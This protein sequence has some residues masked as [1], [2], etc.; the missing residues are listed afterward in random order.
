M[1]PDAANFAANFT[2]GRP[3]TLG[4]VRSVA[5][6]KSIEQWR[7]LPVE[8]QRRVWWALIPKQVGDSMA[9]EREPVDLSWLETLHNT[10]ALP[11][12]SKP[13]KES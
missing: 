9:F 6:Q 1:G 8:E 10:Q 5:W 13:P 4:H 7:R 3:I 11:A 2:V 12:I